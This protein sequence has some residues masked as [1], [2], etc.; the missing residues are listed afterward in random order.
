MQ[1]TLTNGEILTLQAEI[2]TVL[3]ITKKTVARF[4][5]TSLFEKTTDALKP[6]TKVKEDLI[7]EKATKDDEGNMV[8][9]QYKEGVDPKNATEADLTEGFKEY[10]ELLKLDATLEVK[11]IPVSNFEGLE[12]DAIFPIL[13]K[14]IE[15]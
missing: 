14:F 15:L 9:K 1:I 12:S 2:N 7:K 8:I 4:Y 13:T 6:F 10:L 11:P 5:L 3:Q